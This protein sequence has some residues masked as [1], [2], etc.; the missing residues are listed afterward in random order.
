VG[1]FR[2]DLYYR[3]NVFPCLNAPL[4]WRAERHAGLV[5]HLSRFLAAGWAGKKKKS[6]PIRLKND[7]CHSAIRVAGKYPRAAKLDRKAVITSIDGG[8]ES[9]AHDVETMYITLPTTLR[10][11]EREL[12]CTYAGS[13][14]LGDRSA[15]ERRSV[16]LGVSA[17]HADPQ[18]AKL[19]IFLPRLE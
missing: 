5:Q 15:G 18:D 4:R 10:G 6:T 7:V 17:F 1:E 12:I 19:G 13:R 9:F 8:F 16:K 14:R 3:M 11:A 2:D